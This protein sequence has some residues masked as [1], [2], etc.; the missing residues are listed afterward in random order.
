MQG[1][2]GRGWQVKG[3]VCVCV[4]ECVDVVCVCVCVCGGVAEV[5]SLGFG[6]GLV[7]FFDKE[8]F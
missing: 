6:D 7:L 2:V 8:S 3:A 5:L 4:C 1:G